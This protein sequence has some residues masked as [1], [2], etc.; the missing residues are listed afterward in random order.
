MPRSS[1]LEVLDRV[2]LALFRDTSWAP[3]L[4]QFL[5]V[6]LRTMQRIAKAHRE[7][8]RYPVP[9]SWFEI[10]RQNL[11]TQASL[12]ASLADELD[13]RVADPTPTSVDE[14]PE[15]LAATR[16]YIVWEHSFPHGPHKADVISVRDGGGSLM[17]VREGALGIPTVSRLQLEQ[18]VREGRLNADPFNP[19]GYTLFRP[20]RE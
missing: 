1:D 12:Y 19:A 2:G 6:P 8:R 20:Q 3:Q 18:W 4:A 5:G 15:L 10:L 9:A 14:L 11:R 13:A 17:V 16:G 7:G